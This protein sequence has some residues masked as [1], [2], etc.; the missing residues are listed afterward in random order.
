MPSRKTGSHK[1]LRAGGTLR[2]SARLC[3]CGSHPNY[4]RRHAAPPTP[5]NGPCPL[6]SAG[7]LS[8]NYAA[9]PDPC[10]QRTDVPLGDTGS[11]SKGEPCAPARPGRCSASPI[12]RHLAG[13]SL[14]AERLLRTCVVIACT[15]VRPTCGYV[16]QDGGCRR[17]HQLKQH[18]VETS[19]DPARRVH[20]DHP[21][22]A[23]ATSSAAM[24]TG[25]ALARR[26]RR[27]AAARCPRASRRSRTQQQLAS[28]PTGQSDLHD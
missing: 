20:L 10:T 12:S 19:A 23:A 24:P 5:T 11:Q 17:H 15:V 3:Q 2:G 27:N 4:W 28:R 21:G 16:L 22:L 14:A 26:A 25:R 8:T 1:A 18:P 13:R 9:P 7:P 6:G